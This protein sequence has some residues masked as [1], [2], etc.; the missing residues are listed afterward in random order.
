MSIE[1]QVIKRA[2]EI[3]ASGERPLFGRETGR[4]ASRVR[5]NSPQGSVFNGEIGRVVRTEGDTVFVR[6][7]R[8]PANIPFGRGELEVLGEKPRDPFNLTS[9]D[10]GH[11]DR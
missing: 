1:D 5:V 10:R 4:Y 11:N 9:A 7:Q 3:Q 2:A 8:I 6:L